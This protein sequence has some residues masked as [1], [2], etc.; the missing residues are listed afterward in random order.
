MPV[1]SVAVP[2]SQAQALDGVQRSA[3]SPTA[4]SGP[5]SWGLYVGTLPKALLAAVACL[6]AFAVFSYVLV[7]IA[8]RCTPRWPG[9]C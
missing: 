2:A 4:A 6:I 8:A 9:C 7:L 1:T 5:G 3:T